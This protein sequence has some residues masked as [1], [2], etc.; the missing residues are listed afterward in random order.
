MIY[1]HLA[2][3]CS[4]TAHMLPLVEQSWVPCHMTT[5]VADSHILMTFSAHLCFTPD[6]GL[7]ILSMHATTTRLCQTLRPQQSWGAWVPVTTRKDQKE[8]Y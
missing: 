5:S 1:V 4:C 7:G 6:T 8:I 3:L 2:Y